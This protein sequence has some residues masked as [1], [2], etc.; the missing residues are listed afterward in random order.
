[1]SINVTSAE[2]RV[3]RGQKSGGYR[4]ANCVALLG[5]VVAD[6]RTQL[7]RIS[8]LMRQALTADKYLDD[9]GTRAARSAPAWQALADEVRAERRSANVEL[10]EWA[11]SRASAGIA[12]RGVS[13]AEPVADVARPARRQGQREQ[14]GVVRAL[15]FKALGDTSKTADEIAAMVKI[16]HP[17]VK[18]HLVMLAAQGLVRVVGR[19]VGGIGRQPELWRKIEGAEPV[20]GDNR[21]LWLNNGTWWMRATRH[22]GNTKTRIAMSLGTSDVEEAR[23]RRDAALQEWGQETN[24]GRAA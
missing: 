13:K 3:T 8:E 4:L 17:S 1:V 9:Q 10:L 6:D 18:H 20:S 14:P 16:T 12:W 19:R 15:V 2:C 22:H 24:E 23:R 11:K 7:P 5:A 21:F